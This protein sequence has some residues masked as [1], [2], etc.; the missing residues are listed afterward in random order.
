MKRGYINL[1]KYGRLNNISSYEI[2]KARTVVSRTDFHNKMI[3]VI[4]E[5]FENTLFDT[6]FVKLKIYNSNVSEST[7]VL[8]YDLRY[9]KI[10]RLRFSLH[11]VKRAINDSESQTFAPSYQ[12][13]GVVD[14][15]NYVANELLANTYGFQMTYQRARMLRT[16][17]YFK[18]HGFELLT[19]GRINNWLQVGIRRV[20]N[21]DKGRTVRD[22][23][24]PLRLFDNLPENSLE[25]LI[26]EHLVY[27]NGQPQRLFISGLAYLVLNHYEKTHDFTNFL[28]EMAQISRQYN[29]KQI[30]K[31]NERDARFEAYILRLLD[32]NINKENLENY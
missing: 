25:I 16:M 31:V 19:V 12:F 23:Q 15:A 21:K 20:Q 28:A 30:Q 6:R 3:N 18:S 9:D 8:L 1:Y 10:V 14:F 22:K 29:Q 32:E 26:D 4:D 13:V 5:L 11:D 27:F 7:Y 17:T 2:F 24:S